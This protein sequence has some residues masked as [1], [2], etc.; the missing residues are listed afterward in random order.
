IN[1][2]PGVTDFRKQ[3]DD[4]L[5]HGCVAALHLNVS[6]KPLGSRVDRHEHIGHGEIGL[7]GFRNVLGD[8]RL[9]MIPGYLETEKGTDEETGE[10]W[11]VIN[12]RVLRELV[13]E[14]A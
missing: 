4:M 9:G 7:Q 8:E 6:K 2:P 13:A 14:I 5:P 1:K 3:L 11:D 10:E 12:L